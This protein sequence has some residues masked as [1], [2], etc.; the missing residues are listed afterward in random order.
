MRIKMKSL[1]RDAHNLFNGRIFANENVTLP[2]L[3]AFIIGPS[4]CLL[5]PMLRIVRSTSMAN[6]K[7]PTISSG[8]TPL[9]ITIL[10]L[11]PLWKEMLASTTMKVCVAL[12]CILQV[13]TARPP[14]AQGR[15]KRNKNSGLQDI[16]AA[17]RLDE[18]GDLEKKHRQPKRRS[19]RVTKRIKVA[20]DG[21]SDLEDDDEYETDEVDGSLQA[22]DASD[23]E[24]GISNEE[25]R[26]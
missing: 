8:S 25:V 17:E 9:A 11:F 4:V 1:G 2:P 12:L 22:S 20:D 10:S 21:L 5:T 14:V 15:P 16:L 24:G 6:S 18:W 23:S 7:T 26:D 13:L 19:K 3:L